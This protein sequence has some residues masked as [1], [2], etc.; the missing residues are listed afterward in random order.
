MYSLLSLAPPLYQ[1]ATCDQP[2]GLQRGS[3]RQPVLPGGHGLLPA[4]D[5]R[6]ARPQGLPVRVRDRGLAGEPLP[7]AAGLPAVHPPGHVP[8]RGGGEHGGRWREAGGNGRR[9][10]KWIRVGNVVGREMRSPFTPP[11]LSWRGRFH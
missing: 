10:E 4:P 5:R 7:P 9:G 2:Y 3:G 6:G 11:H 8:L 1:T